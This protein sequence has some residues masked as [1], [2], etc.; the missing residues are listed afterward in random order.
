[1]P[2]PA[3]KGVDSAPTTDNFSRIGLFDLACPAYGMFS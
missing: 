1:M 2:R 3:N